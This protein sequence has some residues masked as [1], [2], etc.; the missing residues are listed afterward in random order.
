MYARPVRVVFDPRG[1]RLLTNV[2]LEHLAGGEPHHPAG[3]EL[4]RRSGL[5]IAAGARFPFSDC[6]SPETDEAGALSSLQSLGDVLQ[7]TID[8]ARRLDLRRLGV[9]RDAGGQFR[10]VHHHTSW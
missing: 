10:L 1:A 5:R 3:R 8:D 7:E 6:K 9:T 2:R 4:Y